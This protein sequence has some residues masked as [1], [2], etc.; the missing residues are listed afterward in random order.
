MTM[1]SLKTLLVTTCALPSAADIHSQLLNG[2]FP[3]GSSNWTAGGFGTGAAVVTPNGGPVND[4]FSFRL[5]VI[6][7]ANGFGDDYA[8]DNV[9]ISG[10]LFCDDFESPNRGCK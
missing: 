3:A 9:R 8:L 2:N 6:G 5:L 7:Q 10:A 4:S 1:K